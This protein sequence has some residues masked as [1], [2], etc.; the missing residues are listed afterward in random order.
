MEIAMMGLLAIRPN[1]EPFGS[2]VRPMDQ[3]YTVLDIHTVIGAVIYPSPCY[4]AYY[5]MGVP[6]IVASS[7]AP[8]DP[9]TSHV[10]SNS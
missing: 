10:N 6:T 1:P 5:D 3:V 4:C 7:P 2:T 8:H 9:S